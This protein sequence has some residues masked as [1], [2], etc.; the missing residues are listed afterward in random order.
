V[1]KALTGGVMSLAATLSTDEVARG[2][3]S[4][5]PGVLLHGPTFMGNP[6]ACAVASASIELLL[7]S[8]WQERIAAIEV[9]LR[10]GLEAA[11]SLSGVAD[12]RVLG[13]IGVIELARPVAMRSIQ[14]AFVDSGVWLRPFGRLVYTMPPFVTEPGDLRSI[15]TA[16]VHVVGE[17]LKETA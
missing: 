11:R 17:H 7:A 1:G 6:L 8:P 16:M 13:A 10:D 9:G 5:S 15:T 3:S 4:G 2:V 12:V 14:Q